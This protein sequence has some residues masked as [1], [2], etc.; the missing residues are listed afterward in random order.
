MSSCALFNCT[1]QSDLRSQICFE[2]K[3]MSHLLQF[4]VLGLLHLDFHLVAQTKFV[5]YVL[6]T[7]HASENTASDHDAE[8][9]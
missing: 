4:V 6:R 3:R 5:L 2:A 7:A 8:L 9:S 1:T